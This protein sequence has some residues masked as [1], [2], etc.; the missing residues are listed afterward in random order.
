MKKVLEAGYCY[1]PIYFILIVLAFSNP[2]ALPTFGL[3]PSWRQALY[4]ATKNNF[5][6]GKD[7]IFTYGPWHMVSSMLYDPDFY[8]TFFLSQTY[9]V[10]VFAWF[11]I[12]HY[13]NSF[14]Y[15]LLIILAVLHSVVDI[16]VGTDSYFF[17]IAV[18]FFLMGI[19]EDNRQRYILCIFLL[20]SGFITLSKMSYLPLYIG[21]MALADIYQLVKNRKIPVYVICVAI[22][23]MWFWRLSGQE[24]TNLP[25]FFSSL[26]LIISTYAEAMQVSELSY[27]F[28]ILFTLYFIAI[29]HLLFKRWK[30]GAF[31]EVSAKLSGN[32]KFIA[33]CCAVLFYQYLNFR[34]GFTRGELY[35]L[36]PALNTAFLM[37]VVLLFY[38]GKAE[39]L[40]LKDAL[41]RKDLIPPV[42]FIHMFIMA[43]F[44]LNDYME[45]T[46][47]KFFMPES[48][49]N[50]RYDAELRLLQSDATAKL[51]ALKVEEINGSVDSY[52]WDI[53]E[54]LVLNL[55]YKPR[56]VTQSY[57]SYN[58]ELQLKDLA[59]LQNNPPQYIFYNAQEL[60]ERFPTLS[61][62]PSLLE[63]LKNYQPREKTE[64]GLFLE[65][66]KMPLNIKQVSE[67]EVTIANIFADEIILP[68]P[69][70]QTIRMIAFDIK[71]S[72]FGKLMKT[73]LKGAEVYMEVQTA[74]DVA[75]YRFIPAAAQVGFI[76]SPYLDNPDA[77]Y[78]MFSNIDN[79]QAISNNQIISIRLGISSLMTGTYEANAVVRWRD[80]K[81]LDNVSE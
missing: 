16:G 26:N 69:D 56:P 11:F 14:L 9:I 37:L 10:T 15:F 58:A 32:T 18:I 80:F 53:A 70:S 45:V 68:E 13:H 42:I 6:W 47:G 24:I 40:R 75:K 79:S 1:Y 30:G 44:T 12:Q 38:S 59:H 78:N 73:F 31:G 28:Y 54:L 77:A 62:G 46:L 66:R 4:F 17:C 74:T 81:L 72:L 2:L 7:A 51:G 61:M 63:M 43:A 35:H 48:Y 21:L 27:M 20:L 65:R 55:D 22:S 25:E 71:P 3:D 67:G 5:I 49:L 41:V 29:L 60:D 64:L 8:W 50:S 39:I 23:L 34:T 36:V 33:V 57:S 19:A 52:P 76:I